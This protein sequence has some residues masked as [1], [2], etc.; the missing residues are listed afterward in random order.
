MKTYLK[1]SAF[2][3]AIKTLLLGA[4]LV[5]VGNSFAL[6]VFLRAEKFIKT[7]PD[8]VSVTM[9]GYASDTSA[10]ASDGILSSPGPIITVP[11]GEALNVTLINKL[12]VPTSLVVPGQAI[13][14]SP[15]FSS[16]ASGSVCTPSAGD[17]DCRVRSFTN[18]APVGGTAIYSY[19]NVKPGT[20][21]YQSGTSPQI[22]IQMGLYGALKND[23]PTTT[24]KNAYPTVAYGQDHVLVYSEVDKAVHDAVDAGTFTGSTLNYDPKYFLVNGSGYNPLAGPTEIG[25]A[26]SGGVLLRLLNAGLRTRVPTFSDGHWSV[27]AEDGN[28]YR[29][30]KEQYTTFL[31]AGKTADVWFAP[32]TTSTSAT[33]AVFDRRLGLTNNNADTSGGMMHKFS[34]SFVAGSPRLN[35]YTPLVATQ[36]VTATFTPVHPIAGIGGAAPYVYSLEVAPLGMT[37]DP[38][39]GLV[40]WTPSNAQARRPAAPTLSNAVTARVTDANGKFARRSFNVVVTNVNDAPIALAD[41]F[42]IYGGAAIVPAKGIIRKAIDPDGDA[43]TGMTVDQTGLPGVLS[44]VTTPG[45]SMGGFSYVADPLTIPATG[46]TTRQ[47]TY[48]VSDGTLSSA[49]GTITLNIHANKAPVANNDR[50]SFAFVGVPVARLLPAVTLND[51]DTDGVLNLLSVTIIDRPNNGGTATVDPLS[52]RITYKARIGFKGT[53]TF[54]YTVKDNLGAVS[55]KAYVQVDTR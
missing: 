30:A 32:S 50:Y 37:V 33:Y 51:S 26:T 40:T 14:M 3:T 1:S 8:G 24:T 49:P 54:T 42:D 19:P 34:L 5:G 2:G 15:V 27:V 25:V 38:A 21:L 22:Q 44:V 29:N 13:A 12:N 9:W 46:F 10:S 36:D 43:I 16:F 35:G 53:D 4:A 41:T 45:L 31:P 48:T 11:V 23:A 39:T 20:Y 17:R 47:F 52:G 55:N 28:A 7:M 6:D 18:E